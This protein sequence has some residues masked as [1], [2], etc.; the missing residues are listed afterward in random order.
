MAAMT[1]TTEDNGQTTLLL[2]TA[3]WDLALRDPATGEYLS[4]NGTQAKAWV[5]GLLK[6]KVREYQEYVKSKQPNAPFEPS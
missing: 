4:A 1:I 3:G 2:A 5:I 6:A